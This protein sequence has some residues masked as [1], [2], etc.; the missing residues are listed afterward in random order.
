MN[1]QVV[2]KNLL[3]WIDGSRENYCMCGCLRGVKARLREMDIF[4]REVFVNYFAFLLTTVYSKRKEFAPLGSKFFP[5]RVD[6]REAYS[7]FK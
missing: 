1:G 4:S 5:F 7:F 6:P 3:T 2:G